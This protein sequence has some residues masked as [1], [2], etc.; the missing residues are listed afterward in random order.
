MTMR[1]GFPLAVLV[2]L[3]TLAGLCLSSAAGDSATDDEPAHIVSGCLKICCGALDFYPGQLPLGHVAIA[4]PL[5]FSG[6][7]V[8][9]GWRYDPDHW[10]V[11]HTF[12]YAPANDVGRLLL[13]ARAPAIIYFLALCLAVC[14]FVVETTGSR[15]AGFAA[16]LLTGFCPNLTAHGRLATVDMAA[17]LFCFLTAASF[18]RFLRHPTTVRAV[19]TGVALSLALLTKVSCLILLPYLALVFAG[20]AVLDREAFRARARELR[21]GSLLLAGTVVAA[22]ELVYVLAADSDFVRRVYPADGGAWIRIALPFLEYARNLR[23]MQAYLSGGYEIPQFLLGSF[24]TQGWWYYYPVAFVLKAPLATLLLLAAAIAVIFAAWMPRSRFHEAGRGWRFEATALVGFAALFFGVAMTTRIDLGVR[25]ILPVYPFLYAA[26]ALSLETLLRASRV[27]VRAVEA[28]SGALLLFSV[29]AGVRAYP[30][31]LGYFNELVPARA[32]DRLLVDSNLD[33]GQDLKRLAGWVRENRVAKIR[34]M[35]FGGGD[36][37]YY[38]GDS[39]IEW[40]GSRPREP[41]LYAVSRQDYRMSTRDPARF[42]NLEKYFAG[43]RFRA[44]VGTSI[45]VFESN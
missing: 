1:W 7:Q 45:Y 15:R 39:A 24:S 43:A 37:E 6:A 41:G 31:Y 27:H 29:A 5:L 23:A 22:L 40:H 42:I 33:W 38:L 10:G 34:V 13:L 21:R 19:G 18:M 9:P 2:V 11:G 26:A 16:L 3:A 14:R 4:A 44:I 12:L 35:Y 17:T 30:G 28:T 20:F 25:Y 32:A 8:D 36:L